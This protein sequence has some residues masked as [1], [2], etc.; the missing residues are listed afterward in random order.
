M[1][2][3]ITNLLIEI[4]AGIAGSHFAAVAASDY[5]F[6]KL[7]HSVV[8]AIGGSFSAYFLGA[9]SAM[10]VTANGVFNE[11]RLFEQIA[12]FSLAGASAGGV[13]MLTVGFLKHCIDARRG[14]KM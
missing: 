8:G 1:T 12:A 4:V 9:I 13:L 6:G 10:T 7:G 5:S 3:T 11:P 2:W 14:S